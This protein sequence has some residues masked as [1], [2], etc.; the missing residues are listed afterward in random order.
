VI[1]AAPAAAPPL[2]L[3]S[4]SPYRRELLQRL[5]LVF[6]VR[7]PGVEEVARTG[8]APADRA[9]RL[10]LAKARAI[11]RE[12]P[13]AC[14]IGSDQVAALGDQ[15]LD[16]PGTA[17]RCRAQLAQLSGRQA[18][19]HT[20]AA[21]LWRDTALEHLDA[22][23]VVFR[24]LASDEIGRYVDREQPFDCAGSFRAERLGVTLFARLS[25]EDPTALVGL[26]LIWLAAAL[27]RVGYRLP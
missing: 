13:G 5:G 24:E 9:R 7:A 19:F 20:A 26:P 23:T 2:I 10:A 3:A 1:S 27:R 25:T 8:E 11:A 18:I 16:K 15:V 22:T 4:T 21:L 14:I 12:H 17:E 6:T